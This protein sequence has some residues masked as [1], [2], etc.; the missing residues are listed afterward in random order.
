M[1]RRVGLNAYTITFKPVRSR[2]GPAEFARG[3]AFDAY[4]HVHSFLDARRDQL[5]RLGQTN[6]TGQDNLAEAR[7]LRI[8]RVNPRS[9]EGVLEG[10]VEAGEAGTK[11]DIVDL[12][13]GTTSYAKSVHDADLPPFYFRF[14]F[15]DNQK[16]GLLV[17]QRLGLHGAKGPRVVELKKFFREQD[18]T[19]EVDPV[20][21]R[22]AL[23][24]YLAG[25]SVK[26]VRLRAWKQ[27]T[28]NRQLMRR[29][30]FGGDSLSEGTEMEV[31]IAPRSPSEALTDRVRRIMSN[32]SQLRTLVSIPGLPDPEEALVE[33]TH[34]THG[35][36]RFSILSPDQAGIAEDVTD[37]VNIIG[38]HP[39][40]RSISQEAKR[41]SEELAEVLY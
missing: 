14:A 22:H 16:R 37:R 5:V 12:R 31:T 32:E 41:L 7:A 40:F 13:T 6:L 30:R 39:E 17:L 21:S 8:T 4:A 27:T 1:P 3:G 2:S 34:P 24:R 38:G 11:N 18:V 9:N 36:K 33:V 15:P 20:L 35:R 25:G 29:A 23:E 10:I 28:D 26:E 19:C